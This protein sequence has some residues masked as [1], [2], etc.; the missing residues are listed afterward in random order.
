MKAGDLQVYQQHEDEKRKLEYYHIIIF[1][2]VKCSVGK[3]VPH[4][5]L[6]V[7]TDSR[8]TTTKEV[9]LNIGMWNV[10]TLRLAE[11]LEIL[12]LEMDKCELSVVG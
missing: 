9:N 3:L 4:S 8:R 1:P 10:K 2:E 5:D 11:K 6:R 7:R 12:T